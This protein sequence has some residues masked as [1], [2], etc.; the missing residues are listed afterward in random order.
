MIDKQIYEAF[1]EARKSSEPLPKKESIHGQT[2]R[3]K[4]KLVSQKEEGTIELF[5]YASIFDLMLTLGKSENEA[6][7]IHN[8]LEKIVN[9]K[10]MKNE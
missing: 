7:N 4:V 9:Y 5:T 6:L 10:G 2:S 3:E 1:L 8:D